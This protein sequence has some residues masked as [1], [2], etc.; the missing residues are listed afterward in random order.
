MDGGIRSATNADLAAGYDRVVVLAPITRGSG[1]MPS[2]ASQVDALAVRSKV[3]IT[4]DRAALHAFGRNML[5][6]A[7]RAPAARAGLAQA[8]TVLDA[9][10]AAWTN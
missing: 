6:P 5:D 1:P 8:P 9:V 4:P 2:A 7:S 10:R 3:L